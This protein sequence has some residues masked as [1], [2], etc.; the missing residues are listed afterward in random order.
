MSLDINEEKQ[1]GIF[2]GFPTLFLRENICKKEAESSGSMLEILSACNN[3]IIVVNISNY[4]RYFNN[5]TVDISEEI[6]AGL[7]LNRSHKKDLYSQRI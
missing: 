1:N 6:K 7:E 2:F 3:R 4:R 5:D